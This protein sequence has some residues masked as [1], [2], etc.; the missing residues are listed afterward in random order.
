MA[1]A[2]TRPAGAYTP[3]ETTNANK[4]VTDSGSSTAISSSKVDADFNYIIDAM[5]ALSTD[6]DAVIAAGIPTQ[7]GNA[8]KFLV[9]DG[10]SA[11]WAKVNTANIEADA[12]T[13]D[14]ILDN[15][16][17][18]A[19]M[20]QV[21]ANMKLLGNVS[22]GAGAVAEVSILDEDSMS[23][24]SAT[25]V[26]TQQSI[27]AYIDAQVNGLAPTGSIKAYL[28]SSAPSYWLFLDG[29]TIGNASSG[30]T[31]RANADTETLFT[32]LWNSMTDTEAPVSG[33]RGGSASADFAANKTITLPDAR[34]RVLAGTDMGGGA[35]SRLTS[36]VSGVDGTTLGASGG[37]QY[38]KQHNHTA[39]QVAHTHTYAS[40]IGS[41]GAGSNNI[42]ASFGGSTSTS[43]SA[44]P[45]ITV[46][47]TGSGNSE[48]VQPTLVVNWIIKL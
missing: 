34:G 8:D 40:A 43:S 39:T 15:N 30:G 28:G 42:P 29:L 37:S 18:Y 26:A 46:N 20:Q 7:T 16:V 31:G 25:S 44:Q 47:S 10:S 3:T 24:D 12:V 35:S 32:L 45:A 48:N 9:T 36:G 6:I 4:Y 1:T 38:M 41:F 27:K 11:S 22:G 2:H 5:N 19:K 13:T 17:T 23:S 21:S 14:K 33:G